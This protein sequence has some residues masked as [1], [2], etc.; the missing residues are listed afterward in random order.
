VTDTTVKNAKSCVV[1]LLVTEVVSVAFFGRSLFGRAIWI[2]VMAPIAIFFFPLF[3]LE[4]RQ[5][6]AFLVCLLADLG[7]LSLMAFLVV[8]NQRLLARTALF[9]VNA[10]SVILVLGSY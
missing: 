5:Y 8:K 2:G 3:A 9:L 1:Q 4:N 7:F 6:S 10:A